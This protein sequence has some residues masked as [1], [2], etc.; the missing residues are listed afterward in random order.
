MI[1]LSGHHRQ[2]RCNTSRQHGA[3]QHDHQ[4]GKK[5]ETDHG[6]CEPRDQGRGLLI[7]CSQIPV[8]QCFV[9]GDRGGNFAEA[10]DR[11]RAVQLGCF[12]GLTGLKQRQQLV[13]CAAPLGCYLLGLFQE[14]LAILGDLR[15]FE[16]VKGGPAS[17]A[18]RLDL[19]HTVRIELPVNHHVGHTLCNRASIGPDL[20]DQR[21]GVALFFRYF[22]NRMDGAYGPE[23]QARENHN[24]QNG[25]TR[26]QSELFSYFRVC[27]LHHSSLFPIKSAKAAS[28][29][30]HT[31]QRLAM[32]QSGSRSVLGEFLKSRKLVSVG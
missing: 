8:A 28:P 20:V 7:D 29:R 19:V 13:I 4:R 16:F 3:Q 5:A 31:E 24:H 11:L 9:A 26:N 18:S 22:Q 14:A 23:R 21:G 12:G 10:R 6:G 15:G 30:R 25:H 17:H 32:R 27:E 1:Q 2:G